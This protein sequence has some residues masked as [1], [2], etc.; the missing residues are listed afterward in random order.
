MNVDENFKE[1]VELMLNSGFKLTDLEFGLIENSLIILQ[2]ANKFQRI[3]F[4]GRI[5]T[6]GSDCYYIAFGYSQDI[7]KDRKFFYSL[8]AY[9]WFSM[10]LLKTKLLAVAARITNAFQGDP[11]HVE[12]VIMVS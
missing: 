2:S 10:P 5:E 9:E 12:H 3:F 6:S 8:N 7:F 1:N 11:A 4:M